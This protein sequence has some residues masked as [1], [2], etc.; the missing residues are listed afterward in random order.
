MVP[1]FANAA[2]SMKPN[3]VSETL[4]QS[5]YGF[6]I[7]KVT[8]RMEAGSTPFAKVKDEIKFYLETQ[9]QI[10]VLK[11]LTEG[12]MKNAKIEYLNESYNPKKA[13]KEANPAPVLLSFW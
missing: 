2:F 6:H 10:E 9:K 13:V 1:E 5:P 3:T 11:K 12:L 7:I 4:V 8:D